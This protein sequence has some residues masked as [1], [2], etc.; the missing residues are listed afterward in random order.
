MRNATS[1]LTLSAAALLVALPATAQQYAPQ[2]AAPAPA[3]AATTADSGGKDAATAASWFST[4]PPITIQHIRPVD[5]RGLNMFETP[6]QDTVTYKGFRLDWGAAFTQQV[7]GLDHSNSA[8]PRMV[9]GV[10]ANQL[11]SIGTGFNNAVANLYLNAQLAPGIRVAMTTYLS[12]RHHQET[13]VKDGYLLIDASPFKLAALETLMKYV[14]VKAGHFEINY[15]DAHFRRSDNGNA[16]YNPLVGNYIMDAFTTQIGSEVY[17]R[18][19][20]WLAMG[21]VT[22]GEVRGQVTAPEKRSLAYLAKAGFDQELAPGLRVRLTGSMFTQARSVN[23]TLFT[24]DRAGSR[25]YMVMENTTATEKD[26]A[27]SGA[28]Q[29][30]FRSETRAWVINPFVKVGGVEFFGNFEQARGRAANEPA[31]RKWNQNVYELTYRFAEERLFVAG[32]YN[33]ASGELLGITNDVSVNRTEGGAGWFITPN[34][35][36][37]GEYVTQK[38]KG[39]PLTDIRSGGK[40]DGFMVEGVVAF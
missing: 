20:P 22:G 9:N 21:G 30:G 5:K 4:A 12:A 2:G 17:F 24:G 7:Q 11:M 37:K 23:N 14:T 35:L 15:G 26:Q 18:S 38:Y 27:W 16:L 39:F 25:Y 13:W 29:P 28:I 6:K 19:G 8:Q 1:V 31:N 36:L 10:D 34:L 3:P 33:T 32:R 40:F